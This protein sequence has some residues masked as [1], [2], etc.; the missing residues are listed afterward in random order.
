M[1]DTIVLQENGTTTVVIDGAALL[2]PLVDAAQGSADAAAAD[3]ALA[4]A[5]VIA[6]T[7]AAG[8]D[9]A[10]RTAAN[11][12]SWR[13]GQAL[14]YGLDHTT[15]SGDFWESLKATETVGIFAQDGSNTR[16]HICW[17]DSEKGFPQGGVLT[18]LVVRTGKF[19][20]RPATALATTTGA[21]LQAWV[22]RPTATPSSTNGVAITFSLVHK[23]GEIAMADN[24]AD[25]SD[26]LG[27]VGYWP[28]NAGDMVA[29][30]V[31]GAAIRYGANG[32]GTHEYDDAYS[33]LV[34]VADTTLEAFSTNRASTILAG[35]NG[36]RRFF[37]RATIIKSDA[38]TAGAGPNSLLRL[39]ADG[40]IPPHVASANENPWADKK[41]AVLGS[42]ISTY[43]GGGTGAQKGH[44][45]MAMEALD[46]NYI[47]FAVGGS[48]GL[49]PAT[50]IGG[51]S[52]FVAGT[53]AEFVARYGAGGDPGQYSYERKIIGQSFDAV[54]MPDCINDTNA[55]GNFS[56]GTDGSTDR[57]TL[58]GAFSRMI[59]AILTDR[60]QCAIFLQTPA[61]RWASYPTPGTA[62]TEQANR[63]QYAD[64]MYA[65]ALKYGLP[66]PIDYIRYGGISA[67][68]VKNGTGLIDTIHPAET[69]GPKPAMARMI[70]SRFVSA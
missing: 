48:Y 9:T 28:V 44:M 49:W 68:R 36:G 45:P 14:I 12:E 15:P 4:E 31:V 47:N 63:I 23:L 37:H 38:Q 55:S 69:N 2:A 56:I 62:P 54:I 18:R 25:Y 5:A 19:E 52:A 66:A 22:V 34:S 16:I 67:I 42:S 53:E 70:Y 13:E 35:P 24:Q 21:K 17:K 65:I 8:S 3:R 30:R 20:E 1:A 57:S 33:S 6:A 64:A 10:A 11:S 43:T 7:A 41:I 59:E 60:P 26:D 51:A 39:G 61:H 40:R 27:F 50:N 29:L 46:A 58:W 32:G